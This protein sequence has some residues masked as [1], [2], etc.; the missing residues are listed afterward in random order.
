MFS[1]CVFV[2]VATTKPYLGRAQRLI[3]RCLTFLTLTVS[4]D[5]FTVLAADFWRRDNS[6][7]GPS[8][9]ENTVYAL[10][11]FCVSLRDMQFMV[12]LLGLRGLLCHV[13]WCALTAKMACYHVVWKPLC[14][15]TFYSMFEG[16]V[17]I[18][19]VATTKQHVG[20]ALGLVWF[21]EMHCH[22]VWFGLVCAERPAPVMCVLYVQ[23]ASSSIML[24]DVVTTNPRAASQVWFANNLSYCVVRSD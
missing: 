20:R 21:S 4:H 1:L 11:R 24:I 9:T 10:A 2:D 12:L 17:P 22:V 6:S 5:K 18:L 16:A 15:P 3:V 13:V 14:R 23:T 8:R 19:G 7:R